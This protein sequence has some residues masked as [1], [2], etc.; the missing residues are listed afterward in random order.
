MNKKTKAI[1]IDFAIL[2]I[3]SLLLMI[4]IHVI[5]DIFPKLPRLVVALF[6]LAMIPFFFS[7]VILSISGKNTIGNRIASRKDNMN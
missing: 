1:L 7:T 3:L 2:T 5:Y 4:A 6:F